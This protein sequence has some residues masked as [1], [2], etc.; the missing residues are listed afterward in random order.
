MKGVVTGGAG[1]L[2]SHVADHLASAGHEITILDISENARHRTVNVDLQD[3]GSLER[4]LGGAEFVCHLGAVGDVYLAMEKPHLAAAVNVAGTTN[5]CQAA[6][7]AG[8]GRVVLASTWEVYGEPHYQPIDEAHP[9]APD[10][11]YNITKLAAERMGIAYARFKNLPVVALRLGTAYGTRMRP[12]SV[13]TIFARRALERQP[14][15]LQGGGTQ[16]RQFTHA[17]DIASAFAAALERGE[18]GEAYN[19]VGDDFVTIRELAEAVVRIVPT[20]LTYGEPRPGDVP[21]ARVANAKA[22]RDL[23]WAP[24]MAFERGVEEIVAEQKAH[25]T[26]SRA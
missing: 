9:C 22:K 18:S 20:E 12:N 19:V 24:R 1:F 3:L 2:G 4:A 7:S 10:H 14:I 17:S 8:V 6:V 25:L 23:G 15:V 13:F 21:S 16:G 26:S 5:I 11:P